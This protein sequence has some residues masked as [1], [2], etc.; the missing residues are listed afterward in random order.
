MNKEQNT[1]ELTTDMLGFQAINDQHKRFSIKHGIPTND[2]MLSGLTATFT[3][4]QGNSVSD[5]YT[6]SRVFCFALLSRM[7]DKVCA[8]VHRDAMQHTGYKIVKF[9]PAKD[10][11]YVENE[12]TFIIRR[13]PETYNTKYYQPASFPEIDMASI[14]SSTASTSVI[15]HDRRNDRIMLLELIMAKVFSCP[16]LKRPVADLSYVNVLF[17]ADHVNTWGIEYLKN[18]SQDGEE[19]VRVVETFDSVSPLIDKILARWW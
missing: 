18:G 6:C 13:L 10:I 1:K 14:L 8:T 5:Y 7:F 19:D 4:K 2:V 15:T 3:M 12:L 9:D 16:L 17:P 11:V